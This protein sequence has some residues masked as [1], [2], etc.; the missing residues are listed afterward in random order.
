LY[1][2]FL[3]SDFKLHELS[4]LMKLKSSMYLL[5]QCQRLGCRNVYTLP[6][7]DHLEAARGV[8]VPQATFYRHKKLDRTCADIELE[9]HPQDHERPDFIVR[10]TFAAMRTSPLNAPSDATQVNPIVPGRSPS[11]DPD[12]SLEYASFD[13]C[14]QTPAVYSSA[15]HDE[16]NSISQVVQDL[17][18]ITK[19]V[20]QSTLSLSFTH[21]VFDRTPKGSY[22]SPETQAG[23]WSTNIPNLGPCKLKSGAPEN[24]S[25]LE[26]ER[27]LFEVLIA[28]QSLDSSV[29]LESTIMAVRRRVTDELHRINSLKAGEWERQCSAPIASRDMDHHP[30]SPVRINTGVFY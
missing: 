5:C 15:L 26:H 4:S 28:L 18:H 20:N 3:S 30:S 7:E 1:L 16:T 27:R 29:A 24:A 23:A 19:F 12:D 13:A 11:N 10:Q 9:D 6:R 21:L 8:W 2:F 14:V 17:Q 25:I 22:V